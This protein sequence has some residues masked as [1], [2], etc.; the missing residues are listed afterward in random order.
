MIMA[1]VS[2]ASTSSMVTVSV[3]VRAPLANSVIL[4]HGFDSSQSNSGRSVFQH[5]SGHFCCV[6]EEPDPPPC[7]TVLNS[8]CDAAS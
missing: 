3:A 4:E 6:H 5:R 8:S 1:G 7:R 2:F